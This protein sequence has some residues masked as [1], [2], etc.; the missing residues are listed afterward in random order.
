MKKLFP[1]QREDE[2]IY[3]VIR[4]H[5]VHLALKILIWMFFV[6]ILIL[7]QRFGQANI[8]A[9]FQGKWG[10]ITELFTEVYTLFL[11]LSLFLF[12]VFY[13]LNVG[14]ITSLRVVDVSQEGLFSHIISELHID[15]IED[16]TSE[17]NGVLGTLF[18][19]GNVFIQTA[20]AIERFELHNVPNP[21]GI[22]KVI[23]DLYEK[24]S[25]F[26]KEG[27]EGNNN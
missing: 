19:Y 24:N 12:F 17:T 2:E 9:L 6:A 11:V 3:L 14:I 8:P 1:S 18:G 15:K 26:A 21:A 7:F 22:E 4:E 10:Q 5:W 20:G 16:A 25:N 27:R 13:Y 23:M